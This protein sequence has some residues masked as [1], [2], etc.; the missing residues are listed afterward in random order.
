MERGD[1]PRAGRRGRHDRRR[2]DGE[3]ERE[4]RRPGRV[5]DVGRRGPRRPARAGR[6]LAG[7]GA[8][9][10]VGRPVH[11]DEP[12]AVPGRPRGGR[13]RVDR[14]A[15][16]RACG[17]LRPPPDLH[18]Q[19]RRPS[20][21]GPQL[22]CGGRAQPGGRAG[23]RGRALG[24][25]PGRGRLDPGHGLGGARHPGGGVHSQ[26]R[27]PGA[28][29]TRRRP[30][31]RRRAARAGRRDRGG[32]ARR[33]GVDPPSPRRPASR[34]TAGRHPTARRPVGCAGRRGAR[35]GLRH[36][37]RARR[38]R[39]GTDA[40][41]LAPDLRRPGRRRHRGGGPAPPAGSRVRAGRR[42]TPPARTAGASA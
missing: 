18:R 34:G 7:R 13:S 8:R 11:L 15:L 42:S 36:G 21:R 4:R 35:G 41:H 20:R 9:R 25:R 3:P 12:R 40:R 38:R 31:G 22:D 17:G 30:G 16:V 29:G 6:A 28:A 26:L 2:A 23:L 1:G 10:A 14:R 33:R 24:G 27:G 19:D 5:D 37:A 39:A 32:R